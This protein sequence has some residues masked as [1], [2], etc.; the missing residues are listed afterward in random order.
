MRLPSLYGLLFMLERQFASR[1]W[2][3]D[4]HI[5]ARLSRSTM[6]S[7]TESGQCGQRLVSSFSHTSLELH[8]TMAP[9]F[10]GGLNMF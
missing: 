5:F 8:V 2:M 10:L 1:R 3:S 9:G 4:C 7:L 6:L